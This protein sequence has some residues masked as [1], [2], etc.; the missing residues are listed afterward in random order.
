MVY[1]AL[2]RSLLIL[3]DLGIPLLNLA[4]FRYVSTINHV[5]VANIRSQSY[6]L[7]LD[8]RNLIPDSEFKYLLKLPSFNVKFFYLHR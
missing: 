1:H 3:L 6:L 5:C 8:S 7:M 2:K 4:K